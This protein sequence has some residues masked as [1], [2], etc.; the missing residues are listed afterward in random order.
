MFAV[1]ILACG[2]THFLDVWTLWRP[3][4]G[5]QGL[6]KAITAAASMTTAVLLWALVPRLLEL[7]SPKQLR[8]PMRNFTSWSVS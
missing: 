3:Y 7:P 2:T 8:Q 1:F 4:Y 6:F 5:I